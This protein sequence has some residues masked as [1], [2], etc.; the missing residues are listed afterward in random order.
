MWDSNADHAKLNAYR[1][2]TYSATAAALQ[3]CANS[4]TSIIWVP[5]IHCCDC[6]QRRQQKLSV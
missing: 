3:S 6:R 1:S 2:T 5:R 4:S